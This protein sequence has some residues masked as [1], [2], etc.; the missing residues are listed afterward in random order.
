LY[1]K[2]L[3]CIGLIPEPPHCPF[4]SIIISHLPKSSAKNWTA[5]D[6]IGDYLCLVRAAQN[7]AQD[8]TLSQ[9]ELLQWSK[10]SQIVS[11]SPK[12]KIKKAR[13]G[14]SSG[15]EKFAIKFHDKL[16]EVMIPYKN[17]VLQTARI[18]EIIEK[19]PDFYEQE[20]WIYPSDHCK[21]HTN[22]GACFCAETKDALFEQMARG[23]YRVL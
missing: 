4:D 17:K 9:W 6:N 16:K 14:K 20:Q 10:S 2:Y 18:K 21:N 3:W 11:E 19:V 5:L 8:K 15:F 22:N 12:N 13:V 7:V 1:L 23:K